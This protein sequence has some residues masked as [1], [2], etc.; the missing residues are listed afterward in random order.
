MDPGAPSHWRTL[1]DCLEGECPLLLALGEASEGSWSQSELPTSFHQSLFEDGSQGLGAV[2]TPERPAL[3]DKGWLGSH[4]RFS[5]KLGVHA[6]KM[7]SVVWHSAFVWSPG[8]SCL[9]HSHHFVFI[10]AAAMNVLNQVLVNI[11]ARFSL[12]CTRDWNCSLAEG[13]CH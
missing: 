3:L 10:D 1:G 12:G 5:R 6:H 4:H 11:C 7:A 9:C 13:G 8:D 2:N